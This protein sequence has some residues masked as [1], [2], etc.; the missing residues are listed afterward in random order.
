MGG[1]IHDGTNA[2]LMKDEND[3]VHTDYCINDDSKCNTSDSD[4]DIFEVK[5]RKD[6]VKI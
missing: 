2:A 6:R 3:N 5:F 1:N 4:S